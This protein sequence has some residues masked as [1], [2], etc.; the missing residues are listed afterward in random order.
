MPNITKIKKEEIISASIQIVREEGI[1]ALNARILAKKMNC[2]I[3]PVYY[4]FPTMNELRTKVKEKIKEV[5]NSYIEETKKVENTFKSVGLAY[6]R[7]AEEEPNFFKLLFM[8]KDNKIFCL[9]QQLDENYEYI[10]STIISMYPIT[11]EQAIHLYENVWVTTHGLAVMIAT[12]FM[13]PT[14][15]KISSI[16]TESFRG[17]L[18]IIEEKKN[19]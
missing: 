3:Q 18:L 2:S 11:R 7:F 8:E 4:H 13:H 6:I 14:H 10:L 17:Q 5:Y 16:L 19:D 1:N 15:E 12:G 9:N